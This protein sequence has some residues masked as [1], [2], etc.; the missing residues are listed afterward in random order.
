MDTTQQPV[1]TSGY[2]FIINT[3]G[4][5]GRAHISLIVPPISFVKEKKG[6]RKTGLACS[7]HQHIVMLRHSSNGIT[8]Q[9]QVPLWYTGYHN[10]YDTAW[11]SLWYTG[12]HNK[13]DTGTTVV[14]RVSQ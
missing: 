2:F 4:F 6:Q 9:T 3:M 11:S 5:N 13:S 7:V 1:F 14:Q 10:K 12:Y 8:S